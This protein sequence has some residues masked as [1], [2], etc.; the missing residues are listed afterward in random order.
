MY[1]QR[2]FFARAFGSLGATAVVAFLHWRNGVVFDG[3]IIQL[4]K[5]VRGIASLGESLSFC[6]GSRKNP[7]T[8]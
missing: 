2:K 6:V 5:I 7:L 1:L 3:R 8:L 4:S